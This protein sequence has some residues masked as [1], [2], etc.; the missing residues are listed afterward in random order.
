MRAAIE[1]VT[2][3]SKLEELLARFPGDH[4]HWNEA[5]NR[6]QFIDELMKEC[7]GW[8]KPDMHV[9]VADDDGGRA[10]YVLG[11]P[12]K[13][14]LEAKRP[15]KIWEDVPQASKKKLQ[16]IEALCLSSKE[17]KEAANQVLPYCVRRGA[18]LAV[19]C[20]GPQMAIFQGIT[21]GNEPLKGECYFFDGF[22]DYVKNFPLLWRLL[23]P[24]GVTEN[25]ALN[26]LSKHRNPRLP[27]KAST[28]IAE[29]LQYRYRN[30]L[31]DELRALG[32]I[33]LEEIEDNPKLREDFYKEC[34]V[35]LEAN[36]RHLNLSKQIIARRY[37]RLAED[38]SHPAALHSTGGARGLPDSVFMNTGSKPIV[39][40]G[41]V[42]VGK[43]SFFEN[44]I[45]SV[46][47]AKGGNAYILQIDLGTKA[48]LSKSIKEYVVDAIPSLL[49]GRYGIDILE[50]DFVESVYN[51]DLKQFDR[52]IHGK[53]KSTDKA[54]YEAER[55]KFLQKKI[56]NQAAHIQSALSHLSR[57][58]KKRIV[59]IIDNA[60]QRTFEDQQ[61]AFL[62]AQELA[63]TRA[64]YVFVSLRPS[65]FYLSKTSGALSAYQNKILTIS[66]PPA[67]VVIEKRI[68][69]ALRVAEGQIAPGGLDGIRLNLPSIVSF[70]KATLRSI[71]SNNDIRQFLS[72]IT[73]GN[74]RGVIELITTFCGSPNVDARKI[75]EIESETG[76]YRIPLHEFTKH[77]LL[78]EFTYFNPQSSLVAL[79][80]YDVF[81]AD[82]REHFLR[83]LIIAYLS[84]SETIH[85]K[86]G[87]VAGS[88]IVNDMASNGFSE[89]QTSGALRHLAQKKLI[90]T[91]YSHFREVDTDE[92][93]IEFMYRA[94]SVGI[95]HARHWAYGF[96][97]LDAV[98]T[99]TPIF[100]EDI[101]T[102]VSNLASPLDIRSRLVKAGAFK[103]YLLESW[104]ASNFEARYLDFPSLLESQ[105]RQFDEVGRAVARMSG[106]G[107]TRRLR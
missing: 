84:A 57:G 106:F 22:D 107:K 24:E 68:G 28:F 21:I 4:V 47:Q 10:D 77:A 79:N 58:Q 85:D 64:M 33:L 101:R 60:D 54:L 72:N 34:Y 56:S 104:H 83:P 23:S 82:R 86:D 92:E 36:N 69:F 61:A 41:D 40:I 55:L 31:Q 19:I 100:S 16:S 90:E 91:P 59:L 62:I 66:P 75:V 17:F 5:E 38:A 32:S 27:P 13:G 26:E 15:A 20:N 3:R 7:L 89:H 67:D 81:N 71:R 98:S 63:A 99:D 1:M 103:D 49:F 45:L 42:G 9:E 88:A 80:V 87:F 105:R 12:A 74:T 35:P 14:I 95:Y 52:G 93:P 39:V 53:I 78:G 73:G 30:S 50:A 65:T 48:T 2:G 18:P 29:P 6:F 37:E 94:T 44:L 11:N 43:T 51:L 96:S 70:L 76:E 97:F 25:R 8:Q 46:D 102:K